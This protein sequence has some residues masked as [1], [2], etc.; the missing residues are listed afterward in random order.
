MH[1]RPNIPASVRLRRPHGPMRRPIFCY[2]RFVAP[3]IAS[4]TEAYAGAQGVSTEDENTARIWLASERAAPDVQAGANQAYPCEEVTGP[5]HLAGSKPV[6][7][8]LDCHRTRH[9]SPDFSSIGCKLDARS[10]P[11]RNRHGSR[12]LALG[13]SVSMMTSL[14]PSSLSLWP[15]P[16]LDPL[17]GGGRFCR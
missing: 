6:C 9:G 16:Q 10:H 15:L 5:D 11:V 1:G 12:A 8:T 7:E 4:G 3:R 2:L 14:D 13:E 17:A